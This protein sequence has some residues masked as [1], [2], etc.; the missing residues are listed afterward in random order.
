MLYKQLR[1]KLNDPKKINKRKEV[2][3]RPM[4]ST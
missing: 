1:K 3:P 2:L 4:S